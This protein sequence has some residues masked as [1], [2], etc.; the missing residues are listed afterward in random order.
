MAVVEHRDATQIHKGRYIQSGDPGAV[1]AG[2][3]WLDT[4]TTPALHKKRNAGDSGWDI[5]PGNGAW[6]P[7]V[8]KTTTYTATTSDYTIRCS[9]SGGAFS[10][11]LPAASTSTGLILVIKKTDATANAVTIDGNASETID[12]ATT[13]AISTQYQSFTLQSNGVSWDIL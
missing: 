1:G 6:A 7:T 9:A 2:V 11:T 13:V 3:E 5:V 4:T 12:G 8:A 10:V